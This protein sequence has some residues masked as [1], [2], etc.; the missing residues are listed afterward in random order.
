MYRANH[1][2]IISLF[3]LDL[4]ALLDRWGQE[5]GIGVANVAPGIVFAED[6]DVVADVAM[7]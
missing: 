4:A 6:E 7:D 5:I 1:I 2:G 3:V